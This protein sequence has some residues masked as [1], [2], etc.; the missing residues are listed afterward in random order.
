MV[1][2]TTRQKPLPKRHR[3]LRTYQ[4]RL[5]SFDVDDWPVGQQVDWH[6]VRA[7][8][9]GMDFNIRVLKPWVRDPA[10]TPR[11]GPLKVIRPP[12]KALCIM[13]RWSLD[14]RV[15]AQPAGRG[16]AHRELKTIP[17]LLKQARFNLTGN[18]RELWIAGIQNLA[19]KRLR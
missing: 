3:E 4:A 8:M 16:Q 18:A 12:T 9:N 13:R 19:I 5:K 15:P 7:E 10:F 2:R 1:H 11:Y 17:P 6:L 14:L